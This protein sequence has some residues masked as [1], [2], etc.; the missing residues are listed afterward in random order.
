MH[1]LKVKEVTRVLAM[2]ALLADIGD[3]LLHINIE[4][5]Q[6]KDCTPWECAMFPL[7][8]KNPLELC[9]FYKP[10]KKILHTLRLCDVFFDGK[11]NP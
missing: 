6:R 4:V 9:L 1:M 2:Y 8:V 3:N 11:K 7:M 10:S 5:W